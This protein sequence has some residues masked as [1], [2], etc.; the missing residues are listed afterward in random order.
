MR[1]LRPLRLSRAYKAAK[2]DRLT[3]DWLSSGGDINQEL[4]SQL[5][6]L[7]TRA[8]ELE[9][10]SNLTRSFLQLCE[11]H[12]VG[13]DGFTLQVQSV[14][15]GGD[16]DSDSN[17]QIEKD[18]KRWARAGVCELTGRHSFKAVQRISVRTAARD[19]E[20]L[21]RMHD[22]SPTKRN[23]WGFVIE[24][25]D[26]ARLDHQL[27][28]DMKNGHRV[29]LGIELNKAGQPVA[30]W[31]KKGERAGYA[32]HTDTHERVDAEDIIH[33]FE[34]DRPEQLR[35]ATWLASAMLSIHA[36]DAYQDSAVTNARAGASTMGWIKGDAGGHAS[37][38]DSVGA[39][40]QQYQELEPGIIG[41]L[42]ADADFVG[43]D[44]KYPH[45][46]YGP[47][48]KVNQRDVAAGLGVSYHALTG[49]LT[50]VNFSSIRSG[51]LEE[52]ER[53]KVKQDSF[54]CV[55]LERVYL[56]WLAAAELVG[57]AR[58]LAVSQEAF[59]E[60][61]SEHRWQGRRWSW[62]DPLK[63]IK[64]IVEAINAGLG[65][66]QRFAAEMGVDV[67]ELLDQIA[68]FKKMMKDKG[69]EL[70]LYDKKASKAEADEDEP[71]GDKGSNENAADK[72]D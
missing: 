14:K 34:S 31:L 48:I 12:I 3:A 69:V 43:F 10:N 6:I 1:G 40:G 67:E 62:V 27:T 30:Y 8:C 7:R 72:K 26:P 57:R 70:P 18:F 11:T 20:M 52:R 32:L 2:Q 33:W 22:V 16:V 46:G 55:A 9:Q 53:W 17:S 60:R 35:G 23:P 37:I 29:R 61:F 51:T 66:P 36:I 4:K 58:V 71:E 47:F 68:T 64:A 38:A 5:P 59:Y 13:P 25:L 24:M 41:H 54:A 39:D 49:D 56:R 15:P 21:L 19:G 45:E 28:A 50:D 65:S 63:D 44:P 42:G